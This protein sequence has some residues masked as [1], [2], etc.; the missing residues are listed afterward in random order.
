MYSFKNDY[1]EGAH[2]ALIEALTKTNMTQEDGYG[3]DQYS[4]RAKELIKKHIEDEACDIHFI[5]G[6]TLTNRIAISSFLRPHEACIAPATGH[7][8]T[9]ETGAIEATG[10]KVIE[11]QAENGKLTP[12]MIAPVLDFHHFEH[13]VKPKMVYISN[14]TE[15]GTIY[16]KDELTAL[17]EFCKENDLYLY[18][19]GARL[20]MA[21]AVNEAGV[22]MK[23]MAE[24][25]DAFFIGGAKVGALIGE[26]LVITNDTLKE[27]ML[28]MIKQK[29]ALFSKGRLMGV[30]FMALF[31]DL[32]YYRLAEHSNAMAQ[33][34]ASAMKEKGYEFFVDSPTNQI[35]PVLNNSDIDRLMEK[36][37]FYIWE[38]VDEEYSAVRIITSWATGEEAVQDF[39][40]A[41]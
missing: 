26:A 18:S 24:L 11:V 23:D 21:L 1:S 9:H 36:F 6:G 2:P 34:I 29:G 32:L 4:R 19:D 35:F 40:E 31:E 3:D 38:K 33:Q 5:P 17:S 10:H 41:L 28:Y 25:T 14:P 27:D 8:S 16:T 20:G 39:I 12:E 37:G 22:T 13:M 30:Q 7:I 15:L